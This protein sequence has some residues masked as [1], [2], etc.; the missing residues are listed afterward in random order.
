MSSKR[1]PC[2]RWSVIYTMD[3]D[4]EKLDSVRIANDP[5]VLPIRAAR[6]GDPLNVRARALWRGEGPV[7]FGV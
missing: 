1:R 2:P 6:S 4:G 7:G 3:A 5:W